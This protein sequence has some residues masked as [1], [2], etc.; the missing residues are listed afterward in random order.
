MSTTIDTVKVQA[1]LV[2][3]FSKVLTE[4]DIVKSRGRAY[5]MLSNYVSPTT[6]VKVADVLSEAERGD[7]LTSI[8]IAH[9][10][11]RINAVAKRLNTEGG[12]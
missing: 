8:L 9:S 5:A 12:F 1:Y 2:T 11:T 10:N 4:D 6:G 7:V 3:L